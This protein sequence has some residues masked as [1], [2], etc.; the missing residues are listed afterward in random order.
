MFAEGRRNGYVIPWRPSPGGSKQSGNAAV[1]IS[2]V[3]HVLRGS[4]KRNA[5]RYEPPTLGFLRQPNLRFSTQRSWGGADRHERVRQFTNLAPPNHSS[6]YSAT[7]REAQA[8]FSSVFSVFS[9][10]ARSAT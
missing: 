2:L 5:S 3:L 10:V 7:A 8:H 1:R 4:A 9:V 6:A